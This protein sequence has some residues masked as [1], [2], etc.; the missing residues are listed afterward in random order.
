[1][2]VH[3]YHSIEEIGQT[4]W[5]SLCGTDYPFIRYEFL[6]ALET[7][8][9][10]L[11]DKESENNGVAC[12]RKSGWQP[13]HAIVFDLSSGKQQAV[14]AAPMYL[15]YHSYGEY[16]FD[17]AWAD[18]FHRNGLNYYPKLLG[19]IPYSPVSGS[20]IAIASDALEKSDNIYQALIEACKNQCE[21]LDISSLHFLY[22]EQSASDALTAQQLT[23]RY[24]HQYHWFNQNKSGEAY[25]DFDD[26]LA[27][28]K[29]RK[30]KDLKKE[31]RQVAEQNVELVRLTGDDITPE[32]WDS[33]YHFY[34]RT[35]SKRSGHGGYLPK[36]FFQTIGE[37]M[38][39]QLLL[40]LAVQN[41]DIIA[42][43]LNLFSSN[44]LYG[45]YWGCSKEAEFLHFEACY[46]QGI[47]FCIERGLT[48]FD[49]GAQGEHKV[50]RGFK[51][52]PTWS[53]HWIKQQDFRE[54]IDD[55]IE[56]EAEQVKQN[57]AN[58]SEWL[59]FNKS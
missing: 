33:F 3:F 10:T 24:S 47:E 12:S 31:R 4:L 34:Q 45:R 55:F 26:F 35:Y 28:L 7:A 56:R 27:H 2:E 21:E 43:A 11:D 29:S 37:S 36:A 22:P 16:I 14:A 18:A 1:M 54:A 13:Y 41:E 42:G 25:K 15:K 46:Y 23:Q 49:A 6:H 20:R 52:V 30:R 40:V 9:K 32:L 5:S 48:K 50:Q 39:E 58:T 38:P 51:P 57:I 44:T 17:W 19:A 8:G 53:N 59:P